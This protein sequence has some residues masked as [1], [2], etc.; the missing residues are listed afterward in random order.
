[1]EQDWRDGWQSRKLN[2]G[3]VVWRVAIQSPGAQGLRLHF[4]NLSLG[5]DTLWI[6]PDRENRVAPAVLGPFTEEGLDFW[7][8]TVFGDTAILEVESTNQTE[9]PSLDLDRL[10]HLYDD[11]AGT[12]EAP[13]VSISPPAAT[14]VPAATCEIDATCYPQYNNLAS[15]TLHFQFLSDDGFAYVCSG[16]LINT[17]SSSLKPYVAT[18]NHCIGSDKEARSVEA[19]F[20]YASRTCNA[21]PVF[22]EDAFRVSG[23]RYM[24]GGGWNE[25]DYSLLLLNSSPPAGTVFLGWSASEMPFNTNFVGLHYPRGSWRRIAIGTRRADE[26]SRVEGEFAPAASYFQLA[27]SLGLTESGSS[28]S[29][30]M[31]EAGQIYGTL[32]Y[33]PVPPSGRTVCDFR[34][35]TAAYGR[36][37][38][39][40]TAY[41]PFL[42]DESAPSLTL[43]SS[44]IGFNV[45][46]GTVTG[47]SSVNVTLS[48]ASATAATFS[49]TP[50]DSWLRARS[51]MTQVRAGSPAII[52]IEIDPRGFT[53]SG[54]QTGNV[55]VS[56]GTLFPLTINVTVNVVNRESLVSLSVSPNP[57][58]QSDP[59]PDGFTFFYTL[60][61]T[62]SAGVATQLTSFS[63]DGTDFSSRI[64]EWFGS[65]TLNGNATLQVTLRGR[66]IRV[67]ATVQFVMGGIDTATRRTWSRTLSVPFQPKPSRA[68]LSLLSLPSQVQ[69]D[70]G[71]NDCPWLQYF[72]VSEQGGFPIRITRLVAD[73]DD[74]SA[75]ITDFFETLEIP[76]RG[77]TIGG[78]CWT[79]IRA[80][81]IIEIIVEGVD[82][83]GNRVEARV[84]TR[85]VGPLV[86][87]ARLS[88]N[89]SEISFSVTSNGTN[90]IAPVQLPITLS[91][92]GVPWSASLVFAQKEVSWLRA[93]PLSGIGSAVMS[94]A[95]SLT[96]VNVGTY[97]ATLFIES[98]QS[99]PQTIL[100]PIT[101]NVVAPRAAP[102]L[103]AGG[104]VPNSTYRGALTAGAL[105]SAFGTN[106][107]S[108]V[109]IAGRIPLPNVLGITQARVNNRIAPLLY[110]GDGQINFQ[111]PWETETGTATFTVDVAGQTAQMSFPVTNVN[112][113]IYT[114]DGR[115]LVP[116]NVATRSSVILAYLSGIGAVTPAVATGD[117]P[118]LSIPVN[119]LPQP[120]G[121]VTAT[122]GGL[123]AR[124]F[125]AAIPYGLV[126]LM[127]VN[128]EI[129]PNAPLGEQPL[130]VSIGGIASPPA[131]I[132]IR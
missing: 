32:S 119:N 67:P 85:F 16:A 84:S 113:G 131:F 39:A 46:S 112:P 51:N 2:D 87:P 11:P 25:G 91:R 109:A 100:I 102:I 28:G 15:A 90:T 115:Q 73:G 75:D 63:I 122:I 22:R 126:G 71:S 130:I 70:P 123:A 20:N 81:D 60:T 98:S 108:A 44:A 77:S 13:L 97:N 66:N 4:Q 99:L 40:F 125:F 31:T 107:A 124:V 94:L 95:A 83:A 72:V 110:V 37:S 35:Q 128:L 106:L 50:S 68:Q 117:A 33:G 118:G 69:Q 58:F 30:I 45:D 96:G 29:P 59:D 5:E 56:S 7:S 76:T 6:Y 10:L 80:P 74:L 129:P 36:F 116:Q 57:V 27:Y 48:S 114:S 62:E 17:R 61:A 26:S 34:L 78:I 120:L 103:A 121:A 21:T 104:V 89:L 41:R 38:S 53:T 42:E 86:N 127:Q 88:S 24:A 92:S 65:N 79:G 82:P 93:G 3:R 64:R 9:A 55:R 54:T 1:M 111:V 49:L 132:A 52:T 23:A 8:G 19:Y 47:A 105:A 14:V 43:S 18:A 12:E 101:F